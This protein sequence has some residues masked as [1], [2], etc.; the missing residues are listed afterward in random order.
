LIGKEKEI[1][2]VFTREKAVARMRVEVTSIAHIPGTVDHTFEGV[3]YG[4][5]F[6]V[7]GGKPPLKTDVHMQDADPEADDNSRRESENKRADSSDKRSISK[8]IKEPL[9]SEKSNKTSWK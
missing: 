2:I 4:L 3:G 7:E 5:T 8:E 9:A 1:D 6:E